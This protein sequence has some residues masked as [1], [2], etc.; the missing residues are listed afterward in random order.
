MKFKEAFNNDCSKI[1]AS[2]ELINRTLMAAITQSNDSTSSNTQC[3]NTQSS[4]SHSNDSLSNNSLSNNSHSTHTSRIKSN[5]RI[6]RILAVAAAAIILCVGVYNIGT[7]LN[8]KDN[9]Y[10]STLK[11]YAGENN[12][13]LTAKGLSLAYSKDTADGMSDIQSWDWK[14]GQKHTRI[15]YFDL[16]IQLIDNYS[17]IKRITLTSS[18]DNVNILTREPVPDDIVANNYEISDEYGEQHSLYKSSPDFGYHTYSRFNSKERFLYI[19]HKNEYSAS[20]E[21]F[22]H[23][24]VGFRMENTTSISSSLT[25]TA[26]YEDGSTVSR[27]YSATA[28]SSDYYIII[29]EV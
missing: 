11:V 19:D 15:L 6:F 16:N 22:E 23:L 26:E 12:E 21:D 7:S 5:R 10:S 1:S 13:E 4:N 3:S 28:Y 9:L 25:I 29:K 24:Y 17:H 18:D 20:Y 27:N 2:E 14:Q 8:N